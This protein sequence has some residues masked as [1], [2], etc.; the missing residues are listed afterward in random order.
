MSVH[1][2]W[3]ENT[4]PRR[5]LA[6][7]LKVVKER[8]ELELSKSH[9]LPQHNLMQNSNKIIK[10]MVNIMTATFHLP[11]HWI[12]LRCNYHINMISFSL[13]VGFMQLHAPPEPSKH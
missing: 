11:K 8:K 6:Q 2:I 4:Q 1:L 9:F 5:Q 10:M 7:F 13:K 3:V 12:S